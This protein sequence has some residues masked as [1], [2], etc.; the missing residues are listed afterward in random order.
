MTPHYTPHFTLSRAHRQPVTVAFDAP[1]IV[2]DTGLLTVRDLDQRLGYLA[3]LARRLPDPRAQAFV[4]HPADEIL[5]QQVYQFLADYADCNDA[6]AL[7]SDPLFQILAGAQAGPEQPLACGSTLARF[8]YAF[9]RRQRHLPEEDRPAFADMYHARTDRIRILNE[10]LRD[11]FVRTRAQPPTYVI[12]DIDPTDDPAH[13]RQALSG[14]HGY[15]QQHQYFPLLVF[16]GVSRFP[17]AA[18]L[19]PGTASGACGAIE[20]LRQ[21]VTTLRRAWPE[22]IILVRGDCS[23][24]GPALYEFCEAEGLLYAFGLASNAVLQRRTEHALEELELYHHFY[25]QREPHVQRFEVIEDYQAESWSRPR[26]VICKVECTP[27]GSQRR[28]V[29]SNLSGQPRGIYRGFYVER[30]AVPEQPI[31]E[32]KNGLDLGRLS[33]HG[34]RANAYRLLLHV[35]AYGL[36]VLLREALTAVPEVA[37]ATVSRLRSRL[38]KVGAWV[39]HKRGRVCFHVAASWPWQELWQRVQAAVESFAASRADGAANGEIAAAEVGM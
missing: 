1:D 16:D 37:S 21:I 14:Y 8:Q 5:A 32:L 39:E 13:G 17:L 23:L 7:R 27:Q 9:T 35:V 18:W 34:F 12:L 33:A 2:S 24:A 29:V 3:D 19:R 15:Y 20:V 31:D 22:V 4:T 25:G 11:T 6:D 28:F 36:V 30:G 10:F 26:R 38:W